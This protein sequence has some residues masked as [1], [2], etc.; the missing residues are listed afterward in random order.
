[1]KRRKVKELAKTVRLHEL[2]RNNS[3][4]WHMTGLTQ[5][6][7]P[8]DK[9][10]I[11]SSRLLNAPR[12]VV[13]K[14]LT[15]PEHIQHFW[16]PYGFS[17][18]ISQMD[19]KVGGQWL[20]TMHGPDGKD[21]PNRIIYNTVNAP[22]LLKW[23]HDDGAGNHGFKNEIEL[24]DEVGKTRI[25]MRLTVATIAERDEKGKYAAEGGRQNLER[26]ATYVAPMANS[27]NKFEI[28]RSFP[29]SQKRLFEACTNVEEMKQWFAPEGMT[30]IRADMDFKTG[31]SYHYG[32]ATADGHEMWGL[33]SYKEITPHSSV[34]YAQSF[35]DA[36][37]AITRHPMAPTW[38]A[39]M[40]TR[41]DFGD[42]ANSKLRITWIYAGVEDAEAA[43]FQAA[44]AG[45]TQG[46]TG[47]LDKLYAYLTKN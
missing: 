2:C 23:D 26:L 17:N 39:E 21:W 16:G 36:N 13:W 31:G 29:V 19:V 10:Q 25:E 3:R 9:P 47:S 44:H 8:A 24:F 5:T 37:R 1:M 14:V 34:V 30:V 15:Q 20:F 32:M 43:T 28:E 40:V 42:D 33:V 7:L 12:D 46:W 18:T 11:I 45:M 27:L 35:S 22:S 6:I 38:P 41:F 4:K